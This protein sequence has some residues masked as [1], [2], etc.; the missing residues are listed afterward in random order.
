MCN[1]ASV[2]IAVVDVVG[3]KEERERKEKNRLRIR[4]TSV[5]YRRRSRNLLVI[6]RITPRHSHSFKSSTA[7]STTKRHN[8]NNLFLIILLAHFTPPP[9]ILSNTRHG[10]PAN[11]LKFFSSFYN[12]QGGGGRE[13]R[14]TRSFSGANK[15]TLLHHPMDRYLHTH[16]L[17]STS[18]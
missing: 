1:N 5:L 17:L 2:A 15:S 12:C 8:S 9:Q 10:N 3:W 11:L 7:R 14:N 16:M 4:R 18:P 13:R 6:S